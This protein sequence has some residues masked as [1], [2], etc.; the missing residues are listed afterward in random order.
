MPA[1]FE[2]PHFAMKGGTAINLFLH[3]MPRL[4][5][6]IDVAYTNRELPRE[7][8]LQEISRGLATVADKLAKSGMRV[9]QVKP[10]K[11]PE[12][13]L[14]VTRGKAVVKI[15]VNTVLR[16]TVLPIETRELAPA[17]QKEFKKYVEVPTLATSEL[18]GGK[19]AAALDRQHPRDLFDATLLLRTKR[20]ITK[21]ILQCF[22]IYLAS[23]NRPIHELLDPRRKDIRVLFEN[24]LKGM[25]EE[26]LK[27][28]EL[29]DTR[30][31]L[32]K[33]LNA[34]LAKDQRTFLT[35]LMEGDPDWAASGVAHASELPG[36]LWKLQNVRDLKTR[37]PKKHRAM[38]EALAA[39][40]SN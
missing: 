10:A 17:A 29:L 34:G 27:I 7:A 33:Q 35:T 32:V 3:D 12:S 39:V 25:T 8:A 23:H 19:L 5:V 13:K 6:D 36:L 24:E 1:T 22:L 15:E 38:V 21:E 9:Q 2:A 40:L 30:E 18:Y 20:G 14:L 28:D 31:L 4:S 37:N 16:G 11:D 26:E